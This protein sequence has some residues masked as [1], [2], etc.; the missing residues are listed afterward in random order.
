MTPAQFLR[1]LKQNGPA[2]AYL[3]IGPEFYMRGQCRRALVEA[4]L[5]A[6]EREQG[7]TY[8]DLD[9]VELTAALDDART[10]SLF[11]SRRVIWVA[12]A[13]GA[14][15]KGR[16]ASDDETGTAA[17]SGPAQVAAY[18]RDPSPETVVVFDSSRFQFDGEDKARNERVM[19]FYNAVPAVVEFRPFDN[20]EALKLAQSVAQNLKLRIANAELGALV[21]SLG[22]DASRIANEL[23]KLSVFAGAGGEVTAADLARLV[24]NAQEN[25]IFELVS[26]LGSGNRSRSLSVLDTLVRDGEY[27]PLAL[28]FLATQL[29]M[30]LIA[31]E[32]GARTSAEIL[33]HFNSTG[34][35]IW[36]DRANQIRQT[37]Q[38]FP[39]N[40]L[41]TALVHVFTADRNL[42]DFR[43]DD[44]TVME[45]L[46]LSLT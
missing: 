35:R 44:R 15:P 29:R 22:N 28:S 19:K 30:A 12:G 38:A 25:T 11:A 32:S 14:L 43:P 39:K 34:V 37:L 40:K 46:I 27:L 13:E 24:P 10:L 7:I 23:E 45:Q 17:K 4:C 1:Q 36:P 33:S 8:H 3:F 21:E 2:P 6:G 18:L 31:R 9:D 16:S 5:P 42:R 26:A 41:E 20:A